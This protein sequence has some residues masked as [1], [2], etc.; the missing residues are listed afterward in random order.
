[1]VI[2][3]IRFVPIQYSFSQQRKLYQPNMNMIYL[4]PEFIYLLI[5]NLQCFH[6]LP[7]MKPCIYNS[8]ND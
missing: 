8:A 5:A 1:M 3:Q 7:F 6:L 2:L 4:F